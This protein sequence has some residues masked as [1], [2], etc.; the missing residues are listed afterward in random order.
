MLCRHF[1]KEMSEKENVFETTVGGRK[2]T[3]RTGKYSEQANGT[4]WVQCGETVVQCNV[5]MAQSPRD[6]IDFFPLG[7]IEH[8]AEHAGGVSHRFLHTDL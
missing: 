6:G 5:T 7:A 2:L 8:A 1:M 3:V 4:C